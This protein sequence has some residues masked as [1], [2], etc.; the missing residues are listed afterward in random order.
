MVETKTEPQTSKPAAVT[1]TEPQTSKS[2]AATTPQ[3]KTDEL[4]V[5]RKVIYALE[6]GGEGCYDRIT[7]SLNGGIITIGSGQWYGM[8]AGELLQR[9]RK[10]DK[11]AFSRL[12]TA[13]IGQDLDEADWSSYRISADSDK[14][15]CIRRILCSEAGIRVQ[16]EMMNEMLRS[17]QQESG[18]L[19]VKDTD[20]QLLCAGVRHLG[21][22][23][24][25]ERLLEKVQGG[26]TTESICA[27]MEQTGDVFLQ[28]GVS[29]LRDALNK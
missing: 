4:A 28:A 5:L 14:A 22:E 6:T 10:A 2:A 8:K 7:V 9:I 24:A 27:A 1:K 20:A 18:A 15:E 25:L 23:R 29:A 17:Y 3:K 11:T 26:Y 12:D 19:G 13:G 16:D 21:G